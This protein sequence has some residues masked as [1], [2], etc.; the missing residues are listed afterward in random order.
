MSRKSKRAK[1]IKSRTN[2][3]AVRQMS[4]IFDTDSDWAKDD[5][6]VYRFIGKR[7]EKSMVPVKTWKDDTSAYGHYKGYQDYSNYS[8]KASCNHKPKEVKVGN[9]TVW[10]TKEADV[11]EAFLEKMDVICPLTD[12]GSAKTAYNDFCGLIMW[13]PIKDY[14]VPGLG[15]LIANARRIIQFAESGAR[16]GLWCVGSHGRT[17]MMLA[18]CIGLA[19][20]DVDPIDAVRERHC[21]HCVETQ[22]QIEAVFQAIGRDLPEKWKPKAAAIKTSPSWVKEGK[23]WSPESETAAQTILTGTN[24]CDLCVEPA[25]N[26]GVGK[27]KLHWF[28]NICAHDDCYKEAEALAQ[29]KA[30]SAPELTS[31][32]TDQAKIPSNGT[33]TSDTPPAPKKYLAPTGGEKDHVDFD[34]LSDDLKTDDEHFKAAV[35]STR[36][37]RKAWPVKQQKRYS[38]MLNQLDQFG[39]MMCP[40]CNLLITSPFEAQVGTKKK[41]VTQKYAC[42]LDCKQAALNVDS[43]PLCKNCYDGVADDD[44]YCS[45]ECSAEALDDEVAKE[46]ARL[47]ERGG[48]I[49]DVENDP[50]NDKTPTDVVNAVAKASNVLHSISDPQ[51]EKT[52]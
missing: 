3:K 8:S 1:K 27:G 29:A 52:T 42:H 44:G 23:A 38:G 46:Y 24:V 48:S 33:Q 13:V 18:T 32:V 14:G 16:V 31:T 47:T 25:E 17:G 20:P 36:P 50:R 6:G 39:D 51:A 37:F 11:D 45:P 26:V 35:A 19:E 28:G 9:F 40:M 2:R 15:R 10:P 7:A 49:V 4:N 41:D 21:S 43:L 12:Y 22:S 34:S 5:Q 30:G